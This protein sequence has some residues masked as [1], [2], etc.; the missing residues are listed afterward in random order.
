VA[1]AKNSIVYYEA[2]IKNKVPVE[3]H[4]YKKGGHGFGLDREHSSKY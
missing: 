3:L 4:L 2:L 1:S